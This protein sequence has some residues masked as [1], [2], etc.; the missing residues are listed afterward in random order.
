M[1][2]ARNEFAAPL[3][4]ATAGR[5][6]FVAGAYNLTIHADASTADLYRA[7][8]EGAA[9]DVRVEDGTVRVEYSRTWRRQSADIV[10]NAAVPWGVEVRGGVAEVKAD[11][12][13]LRLESLEIDGGSHNV[14]LTIPEPSGTVSIRIQGGA[15]NL[16]VCRPRDTA[17][18]V[19]V[20][21]GVS[22][23]A[24]DNQYLDAVGSEVALESGTYAG[25]TDRYE[26]TVTDGANNVSVLTK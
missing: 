16:K 22:K 14:E 13:G 19:H 23:L 12:S 10:L 25:S 8:F 20:E 6:E 21:D 4:S 24:L 2:D 9:P 7:S 3:G 11:L 17:A 15:N 5:L 18:R 26:I 1:N